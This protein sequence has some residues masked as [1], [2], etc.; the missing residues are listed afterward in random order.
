MM[1][2]IGKT[3]DGAVKA[4]ASA[5]GLTIGVLVVANTMS[6]GEKRIRIKELEK[7]NNE[8]RTELTNMEANEQ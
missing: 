3:I 4:F 7:E 1:A 6:A 5:C 8:L 2:R